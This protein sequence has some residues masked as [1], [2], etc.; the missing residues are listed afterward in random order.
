MEVGVDNMEKHQDMEEEKL[1][2]LCCAL[3]RS[4][5]RK[6]MQDTPWLT[7]KR[8]ESLNRILPPGL[9]KICNAPS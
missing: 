2:S 4:K 8:Q 5:R 9:V 7:L 1:D 3:Q 6:E